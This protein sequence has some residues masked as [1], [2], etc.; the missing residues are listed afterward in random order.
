M[1]LLKISQHLLAKGIIGRVRQSSIPGDGYPGRINPG[2][3]AY[4]KESHN[5]CEGLDAPGAPKSLGRDKDEQSQHQSN[6]HIITR[7]NDQHR[8]KCKIQKEQ[9]QSPHQYHQRQFFFAYQ[10]GTSFVGLYHE[11]QSAKPKGKSTIF[12]QPESK[13]CEVFKVGHKALRRLP[14]LRPGRIGLVQKPTVIKQVQTNVETVYAVGGGKRQGRAP[15]HFYTKRSALSKVFV[16]HGKKINKRTGQ[17]APAIDQHQ[18]QQGHAG[19]P[20]APVYNAV[21]SHDKGS[22]QNDIGRSNRNLREQGR[23]EQQNQ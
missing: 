12:E 15:Q 20:P 7:A 19:Q 8:R 2:V 23:F 22:E 13:C 6:A 16:Q 11:K 14:A 9:D 17:H 18:K 5:Q 21:Q 3:S 1:V 10:G 4:K